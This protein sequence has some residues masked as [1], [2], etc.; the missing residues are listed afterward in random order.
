MGGDKF[1]LNDVHSNR[2]NSSWSLCM[3]RFILCHIPSSKRQQDATDY[4]RGRQDGEGRGGEGTDRVRQL[5]GCVSR[6]L[7]FR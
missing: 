6:S 2:N 7:D 1:K 4:E 3:E 5:R